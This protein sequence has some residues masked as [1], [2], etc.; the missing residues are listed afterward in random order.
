MSNWQQ[1]LRPWIRHFTTSRLRED[2]LYKLTRKEL[3]QASRW[4][5]VALGTTV[6]LGWDGK[7][8][9]ATG[10]GVGTM[11]LVYQLQGWQGQINWQRWQRF[12]RAN[13][14][15]L[16]LAVAG[17]SMVALSTY[18]VASV[19]MSTENR[20]LLVGSL[21]EG[22]GILLTLVLV[23][24][25]LLLHYNYQQEQTFNKLLADLTASDPLKRLIAVR[26]LTSLVQKP[27]RRNSHQA[28]FQEYLKMMFSQERDNRVR[29]A[30]LESLQCG[31][32]A[33]LSPTVQP[34]KISTSLS[35]E[36]SQLVI[37]EERR[38]GSTEKGVE[39]LYHNFP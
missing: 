38:E 23:S 32:V 35:C 17:G 33:V 37:E 21:L 34:V 14:G 9:L 1:H 13:Q 20:W 28:H 11:I 3:N 30:I 39:R 25:Q 5:L 24:W 15:K 12:F 6:M 31:K 4:F 7:L 16:T 22:G 10:M 27:H 8:V 2:Y 26:E 19:W 29:Q 18:W 36:A